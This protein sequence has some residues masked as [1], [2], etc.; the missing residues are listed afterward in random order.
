[1][2]RVAAARFLLHPVSVPSHHGDLSFE[3]ITASDVRDT[4]PYVHWLQRRYGIE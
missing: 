2:R 4:V 1:M 3:G